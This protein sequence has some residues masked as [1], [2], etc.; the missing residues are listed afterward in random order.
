MDGDEQFDISLREIQ[1]AS[2][3]MSSSEYGM[4]N[5]ITRLS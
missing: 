5:R 3:C 2:L 1:K 4:S